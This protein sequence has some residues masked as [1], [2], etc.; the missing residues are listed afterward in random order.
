MDF[1]F[2]PYLI[3]TIYYWI[4]I[5][6]FYYSA[7]IIY[8][9]FK[10][11]KIYNKSLLGLLKW[12]IPY[13]VILVLLV[14]LA[15]LLNKDFS[16]LIAQW[17]FRYNFFQTKY[18][19]VI[20]LNAL[21]AL[22]FG[23]I[24]WFAKLWAAGDAKFF[25][26]IAL[27][28]PLEFYQK[29]YLT[30][31]PSFVLLANIIIPLFLWLIITTLLLNPLK[32]IKNFINNPGLIKKYL[33][34]YVLKA[35]S[36]TSKDILSSLVSFFIILVLFQMLRMDL[37]IISTYFGK[38][39]PVIYFGIGFLVF[40]PMRRFFKKYLL[41]G[42]VGLVVYIVAGLIWFEDWL[43]YEL[44][45]VLR[46][47]LFWMLIFYFVFSYGKTLL[48]LLY[49]SSEVKLI[50]LEEIKEGIFINRKFLRKILLAE[51]YRKFIESMENINNRKKIEF[52]TAIEYLYLPKV[53]AKLK[54]TKNFAQKS[55]N[56]FKTII[57]E[58]WTNFEADLLLERKKYIFINNLEKRLKTNQAQELKNFLIEHN[59]FLKD[60]E[61]ESIETI[62]VNKPISF[63]PF[64][65]LGVLITIATGDMLVVQIY[66]FI[67]KTFNL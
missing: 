16:V 56:E 7:K 33:K 42:F 38:W 30:F 39:F 10:D 5:V 66:R 32:F 13:F 2:H 36:L 44:V 34:Q 14:L 25:F 48:E 65:F 23:F 4:T 27:L 54:T 58:H 8:F 51:K 67:I 17:D 22:G 46:E 45:L 49:N 53:A 3:F 59:H 61:E 60:K 26:V 37:K 9:D 15:H 50:K 47:Q 6:I 29:N 12:A 63:A 11:N 18:F 28:L 40:G 41:I 20:F 57:N 43:T 19:L 64:I 21:I 52:I 35:K 24:L 62:I 31:F 55:L 1:L